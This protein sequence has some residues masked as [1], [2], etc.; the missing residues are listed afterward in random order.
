MTTL[1]TLRREG[2]KHVMD[3]GASKSA[4]GDGIPTDNPSNPSTHDQTVPS[5][6]NRHKQLLK[7]NASYCFIFYFIYLKIQKI[8]FLLSCQNFVTLM[9]GNFPNKSRTVLPPKGGR[10]ISDVSLLSGILGLPV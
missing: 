10:G 4:A 9:H 6:L 5:L 1:E 2:Q 7:Q 3:E 8:C